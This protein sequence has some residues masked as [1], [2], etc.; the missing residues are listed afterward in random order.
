MVS[1][2]W[3]SVALAVQVAPQVAPETAPGPAPEVHEVGLTVT[4]AKGKPVTGLGTRDVAVLENGVAR[5]VARFELDERPLTVA[6][7][8]D[9]SE[10]MSS[11]LR[12]HLIDGVNAFLTALPDGTRYAVW[13]TGD[14]PQKI[15]DYTDDRGAAAKAL[16]RVFAQGGNTVL[17]ALVEASRDLKKQEGART[18]VVALTAL[19][20]E[21]SDRTR[22]RVVEEA[23]GNAGLFSSL[24]IDE[25]QAP[26]DTRTSY[27]YC[28]SRLAQLSGG[29]HE[30]IVSSMGAASGL[31]KL[32]AD[33]RAHYRLSYATEPGLKER[34]IEIRVARPGTKVRV[35]AERG[36]H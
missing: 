32:A 3:L 20:P 7:L 19:G 11:A 12:L 24:S 4:D 14:R 2:L 35:A 15:V 29:L 13:R 8:V 34:R 17:D 6:V 30:R 25:G 1:T 10:V 28:L 26:F 5:D 18:A 22:Y 9:T 21:F 36:R 33:L 31:R 27:E 16:K 23:H